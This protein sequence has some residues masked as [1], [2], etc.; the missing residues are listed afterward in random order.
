M[1][2]IFLKR[3]NQYFHYFK[4]N[5]YID[6]DEYKSNDIYANLQYTLECD[7]KK[8]FFINVD[9]IIRKKIE[10]FMMC[11]FTKLILY[12]K[13]LIILKRKGFIYL[14]KLMVLR[15]LLQDKGKE[16]N[17]IVRGYFYKWFRMK[18]ESIMKN[19]YRKD[20]LIKLLKLE[21]NEKNSI[22]I[23]LSKRLFFHNLK[24]IYRYNFEIKNKL[25]NIATVRLFILIHEKLKKEKINVIYA[26][27]NY[28]HKKV[29]NIQIESK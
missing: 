9:T 10:S 28:I 4:L 17:L 3:L 6:I 13:N 29:Y 22:F 27:E 12:D 11:F 8:L 16:L 5:S 1:K 23:S 14:H 19:R 21:F 26:I 7:M 2:I 24:Q 25:V 20:K 15:N 18:N